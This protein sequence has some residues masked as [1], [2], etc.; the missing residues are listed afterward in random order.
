M[1]L[2]NCKDITATS[3][4]GKYDLIKA[5]RFVLNTEPSMGISTL[6]KSAER[7]R[8]KN[9]LIL[10]NH[11][12]PISCKAL[13]WSYHYAHFLIHGRRTSENYLIIQQLK[14]VIDA[15]GLKILDIVDMN[16]MSAKFLSLSPCNYFK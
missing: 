6:R 1:L 8:D 14:T 12:N 5:F 15:V 4:E 2:F 13:F 11:S 10:N 16:F 7:L 9:S 3:Q